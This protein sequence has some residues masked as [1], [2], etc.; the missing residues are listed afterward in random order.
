MIE[1]RLN[2]SIIEAD[3]AGLLHTAAAAVS[4]EDDLCLCLYLF[5][6]DLLTSNKSQ[7][8]YHEYTYVYTCVFTYTDY[9]YCH[10]YT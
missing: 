8:I 10:K 7:T 6:C 3:T 5:F 4:G 2:L 1:G 9:R